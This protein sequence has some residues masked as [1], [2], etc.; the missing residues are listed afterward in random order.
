MFAN[1][2]LD[3]SDI[4][5]YGFDYDYTLAAYKLKLAHFIYDRALEK[6]INKTKVR[7]NNLK[8]I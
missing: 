2:E 3:L 1:N 8:I 5:V 6:L 7:F 4:D